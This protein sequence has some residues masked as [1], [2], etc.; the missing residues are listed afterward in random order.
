[1]N[2]H[3]KPSPVI[4]QRAKELR[5]PLTPPETRLWR[6]LRDRRLGGFKFRR[7][8]PIGRFIVDFYC[9]QVRLVVELDGPTHEDQVEYDEVR[10]EWLQAQGYRVIRFSN[11]QVVQ[12]EGNVARAILA[13]CQELALTPGPS[14]ATGEGS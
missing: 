2:D 3:Q 8:H 7:Q 10:T 6:I 9:M 14:P 4:R 13:K 12:S 5:Q 1:M 11:Q